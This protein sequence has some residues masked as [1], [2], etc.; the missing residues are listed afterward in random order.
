MPTVVNLLARTTA[1]DFTCLTQAQAKSAS[2]CWDAVGLT[3]V[4]TRSAEG[5]TRARSGVC[6]SHPPSMLRHS[7]DGEGADGADRKSTRLNSSHSSISYA[8][9]CLKKKH[10]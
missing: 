7:S 9:F 8:V 6:T 2:H 4:T 1:F 3:L 5:S 10:L